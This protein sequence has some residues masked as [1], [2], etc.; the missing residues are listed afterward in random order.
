M[1]FTWKIGGNI[2]VNLVKDKKS[3]LHGV[4]LKSNFLLIAGTKIHLFGVWTIT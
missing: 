4:L 2:S 1:R 3:D